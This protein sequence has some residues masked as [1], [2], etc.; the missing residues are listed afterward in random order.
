MRKTRLLAGMASAVLAAAA[1]ALPVSATQTPGGNYTPPVTNDSVDTTTITKYL[2]MDNDAYAPTV[3][4]TY[5]LTAGA[6][7]L[8]VEAATYNIYAGILEGVEMDGTTGTTATISFDKDSAKADADANGLTES[9]DADSQD[10]VTDSFDIDFSNVE[11]PEP[12]IYRYK[13]A[14][15][16]DL[17]EHI[18]EH[19][20]SALDEVERTIDVFV[21]DNS[22]SEG[23]LPGEKK[24]KIANIVLY[25]DVINANAEDTLQA[26]V[27]ASKTAAFNNEYT[28]HDLTLSK[29]VTG[30]QGSK[31]K[32]FAFEVA[33]TGA[34]N[35]TQLDIGLENADA[36]L[37]KSAKINQDITADENP[38]VLYTAA[39]GSV[40]Q[41]FYLMHG[42]SLVIKGLPD[43][44][45]YTIT[46]DFAEYEVGARVTGDLDAAADAEILTTGLVSDSTTGITDDTTVAY[47]NNKEGTIP[48][49]VILSVAAPCAA[50]AAVIGGIIVLSVKKKRNEAED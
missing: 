18:D 25:T 7:A 40:T 39:D 32:Y 5:T 50:G 27:T 42:Q 36:T 28:S 17:D 11:F 16:W 15:A 26:A 24:L 14:E 46:E 3:T 4:M 47:T 33:I 37:D 23:T 29:T 8:S 22:D 44:A 1:M 9:F 31:D 20:I 10:Y 41:T 6:E 38:A 12:G 21:V 48:T 13:I 43:G 35:N 49:G 19:I 30:N 2:I 45:K 34:G